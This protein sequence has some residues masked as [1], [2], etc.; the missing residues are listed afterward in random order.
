MLVAL[1]VPRNEDPGRGGGGASFSCMD[2]G[3]HTGQSDDPASAEGLERREGE[4]GVRWHL[5]MVQMHLKLDLGLCG[6]G[7]RV[8]RVHYKGGGW[9][10]GIQ[11]EWG[12]G[13]WWS[14]STPNTH[15]GGQRP[16]GRSLGVVGSFLPRGVCRVAR[17]GWGGGGGVRWMVV[18]EVC[19]GREEGSWG[20]LKSGELARPVQ[21]YSREQSLC[22]RSPQ[23]QD[24][25]LARFNR[26]H[27]PE[28]AQTRKLACGV[29]AQEKV[30]GEVP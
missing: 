3:Y 24:E 23:D 16:A 6:G 18:K 22:P 14:L 28:C 2:C 17:N 30:G 21:S 4:V 9:V 27:G 7:G 15:H 29:G 25:R 5:T 12:G 19:M 20:S 10:G 11:V 8:A 13:G 1:L 26:A